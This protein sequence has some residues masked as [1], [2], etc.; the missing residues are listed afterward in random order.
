MVTGQS[1]IDLTHHVALSID[2]QEGNLKIG[3]SFVT[4]GHTLGGSG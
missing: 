1:L 4:G 2:E 3:G